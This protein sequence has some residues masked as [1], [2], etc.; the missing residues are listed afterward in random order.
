MLEQNSRRGMRLSDFHAHD[1]FILPYEPEK[2]YYL[3]TATSG[4]TTA[5]NLPTRRAGVL[6][7]RS[8]NLKTWEGPELVFEVPDGTWANPY[9]GAW[10]PEVHEYKGRYYLFVT[11]HNR[12]EIIARP[13]EV[14]R[15]N[16]RRGT[17]IAVADHP[18][19]P[20]RLLRTDGPYPPADFMTL[21]GTLYI[22]PEG[23]PWM[24]YA[25]EWIQIIDGTFEAI[26]LRDDLS[27]T[28]GSP[29]YLFKASDGPWWNEARLVSRKERI[30]VSDGPQLFRTRTGQ[31]LMLWSSHTPQE[32]YVQAV[33]RSRSGQVQGP[34]EQLGIL[35]GNDSGH[36][37]LFRSFDGR[38][39]LT[40]HHPFG[41]GSRAYLYQI[42][43]EGSHLRVLGLLNP[44][45]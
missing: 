33:A 43:D 29:V 7:Y 8:Q 17:T 6:A 28:L 27:G 42:E 32:G 45:D 5:N 39:L 40:L 37:M 14:W 38:L 9:H 16:H 12:D 15:I 44:E 3:Y 18:A 25:H 13:P 30:Y 20:F 26:R 31:L 22:D 35:I 4:F 19:G 10:A 11:L 24:V 41:R 1:P 21:D 2:T 23:Q 36:G 34:W